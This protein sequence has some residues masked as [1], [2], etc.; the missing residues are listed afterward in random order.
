[1]LVCSLVLISAEKPVWTVQDKAYYADP[2]LVDYVRPGLVAEILGG[3]IA[4]DGTITAQ[5]KFTDP[6]R[7]GSST[8]D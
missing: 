7:Q 4:A 8:R 6:R 1:V 2:K 5:L 3:A